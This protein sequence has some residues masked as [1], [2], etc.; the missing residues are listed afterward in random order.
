MLTWLPVGCVACKAALLRVLCQGAVARPCSAVA[1]LDG[2]LP[3]LLCMQVGYKGGAPGSLSQDTLASM[4][5]LAAA[6]VRRLA[7]GLRRN[8]VRARRHSSQG[9][10]RSCTESCLLRRACAAVAAL[11]LGGGMKGKVCA[12]TG[13]CA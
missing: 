1:G 2:T 5:P 3:L 4:V 10:T 9:P 13:S 12:G 8:E 6:R 7:L 11:L